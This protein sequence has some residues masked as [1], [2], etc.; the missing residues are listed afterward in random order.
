M[1]DLKGSWKDHIPLIE[2]VYNNSFQS[3]IG[4]ASYEVLYKR[5]CRMLVCWNE[6]DD[7]SL[8]GTNLVKDTTKKIKILTQKLQI[9][10]SWQHSYASRYV[11]SQVVAY[12]F[13]KVS[14]MKEVKRFGKKEKLEP[15]FL[16]MFLI[17]ECVGKVVD[18]LKL[19]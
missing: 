9:T 7:A 17:L 2:F 15:R 6:I 18:N 12:V 8:I 13:L 1:L 19:S 3:N 14:L 5:P 16:G 4:T 11:E 10:Q